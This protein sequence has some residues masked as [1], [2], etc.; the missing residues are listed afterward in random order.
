MN[1]WKLFQAERQGDIAKINGEY[2]RIQQEHHDR[3]LGS[4][5]IKNDARENRRSWASAEQT[6]MSLLQ[7][8]ESN[9]RLKDGLIKR[10]KA[11]F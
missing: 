2:G 10:V 5:M 1:L 3:F 11:S 6:A 8:I 9:A 7:H 4:E